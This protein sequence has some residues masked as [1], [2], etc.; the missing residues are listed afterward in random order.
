M[1]ILPRDNSVKGPFLS[2]GEIV[3]FFFITRERYAQ[4]IICAL[5]LMLTC[6]LVRPLFSDSTAADSASLLLHSL[7]M[8]VGNVFFFVVW[9]RREV[10]F[11]SDS[12]A[13]GVFI[14]NIVVFALFPFAGDALGNCILFVMS[15]GHA[16]ALALLICICIEIS[17]DRAEFA[18]ASSCA[19]FF[20]VD[21]L[22]S[23]GSYIG[24][25]IR[26]S[27]GDTSSLVISLCAM[28][29]VSL[30]IIVVWRI[31]KGSEEALR[32]E[33]GCLE[34]EGVF[35]RSS[36]ARPEEVKF[37]NDLQPERVTFVPV[38][39]DE[40]RTSSML[41]NAYGISNRELDVLVLIMS[42]KNTSSIAKTLFISEN[43]VKAHKKSLFK[44][45]G[46]HSTQELIDVVSSV[47]SEEL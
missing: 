6:A 22:V 1:P 43:T 24:E 4:P 10:L 18:L 38:S 16:T 11:E 9:R 23:V 45:L 2:G 13:F 30:S 27:F 37:G 47:L 32:I 44:K 33:A 3:D 46:V 40:L 7:G 14:L 36:Y 29:A 34:G 19:V 20:S 12:I 28:V 31:G 35:V 39:E 8:V 42:A 26:M 21:L 25:S 15:A 41:Q 17:S 5:L